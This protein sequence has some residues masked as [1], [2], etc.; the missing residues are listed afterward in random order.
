MIFFKIQMLFCPE[1]DYISLIQSLAVAKNK[2]GSH[3]FKS[4]IDQIP[5][6]GSMQDSIE[7]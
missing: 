1:V 3:P 7:C 2:K 5:R 6:Y 4:I